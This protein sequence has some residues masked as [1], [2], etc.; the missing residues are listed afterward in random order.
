LHCFRIKRMFVET[1][2]GNL[3]PELIPQLR[4][5][6]LDARV[7]AGFDQ[8]VRGLKSWLRVGSS[9]PKGHECSNPFAVASGT[10]PR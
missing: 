3:V 1:I 10:N 5:R 7:F 6:R 9:F 8:Y 2:G 4:T